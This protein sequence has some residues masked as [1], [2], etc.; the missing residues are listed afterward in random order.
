[1]I[2]GNLAKSEEVQLY[3]EDDPAA[4]DRYLLKDKNSIQ[5]L[6]ESSDSSIVL[7]KPILD[8][9][10]SA[11]W[12]D[13]FPGAKILFVF[14][15]FYDVVNSS[16]RRFGPV[17]WPKTVS[18]WIRR[19]FT[20]VSPPLPP[21]STRS[22][23]KQLW[24][25]DLAPESAS[26]LYWYYFNRLYFDLELPKRSEVRL[27]SY[28]SL[29]THPEEEMR[30]VCRFLCADYAPMMVEGIT[31]SS[32]NKDPL[33]NIENAILNEC[34]SLWSQLVDCAGITPIWLD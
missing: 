29:V 17:K 3:N 6:I 13:Q 20:T 25:P 11:L 4:F 5:K 23:V 15:H 10:H 18:G 12:L 14:R 26:A 27:I 31:T 21:I 16:L 22:S 33:P 32:I 28:E 19:E 1:M 34:T 7:F 24:L 2:S 9:H 30:D 8:T